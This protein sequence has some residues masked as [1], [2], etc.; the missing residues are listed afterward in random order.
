[1][2]ANFLFSLPS[3]KGFSSIGN[4]LYAASFGTGVYISTDGGETW[5][6]SNNGLSENN[7]WAI[8]K[9]GN[10]LYVG[11]TSGHIYKSQNLGESWALCNDGISF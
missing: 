3:V 9:K 5:I 2:V 6:L 7:I 8:N 10:D 11:V 1:M 4:N